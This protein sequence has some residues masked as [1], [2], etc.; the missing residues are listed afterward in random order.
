MFLHCTRTTI[1]RFLGTATHSHLIQ[2]MTP[3]G[4]PR[5]AN[6]V[7][8]ISRTV[9]PNWHSETTG[10]LFLRVPSDSSTKSGVCRRPLTDDGAVQIKMANMMNLERRLNSVVELAALVAAADND[11]VRRADFPV[12]AVAAAGDV[13]NA[14]QDVLTEDVDA[15]VVFLDFSISAGVS[16]AELHS[17]LVALVALHV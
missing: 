8:P 2:Y 4:G 1:R 16:I 10:L 5:S 6:Q 7:E 15:F 17:A 13:N 9:F 3:N 12:T 14:A 11:S